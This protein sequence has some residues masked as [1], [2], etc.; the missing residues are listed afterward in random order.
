MVE[1]DVELIGES[2][3]HGPLTSMP[4]AQRGTDKLLMS[5]RY[6]ETVREDS[7]SRLPGSNDMCVCFSRIIATVPPF[8]Q[9]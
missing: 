2:A 8:V 7:E 3:I 1:N 6:S 5:D 4:S 9:C